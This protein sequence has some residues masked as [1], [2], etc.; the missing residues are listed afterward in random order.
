LTVEWWSIAPFVLLLA[1]IAVLPL[2]RATERAWER[3]LVKLAVALA[4]GVPIAVW[5]LAAGSGIE[6]AHALVEYF[7][8]IT[9]LFSLFVVSGGI[10][11]SGDIR[12]TPRN[13]TIFLAVG[14]VIAS[15]IGT[16]GA[17]MLL[18]RP[19]LNTNKERAHRVHTVVF[20]IFIVANCGGLLTPLGDPP[21]FLGMLR[22]VPFTWTFS[23]WPQWLFVGAMLL[24]TY[25][26]LDRRSYARESADAIQ[27][28]NTE[29]V[30]LGVRGGI[31]LAFLVV[32]IIAVAVVPSVDLHAI[33]AGHATFAQWMPWREIA[34]GAAAGASYFLGDKIARFE[35]NQFTWTPIR[36]VAAL[37]IGIFL[38]MIPA[39]NFLGQVAPDLPLN[40]V[41][42]F[43]F[44][45]GLS[46]VLDNAPTYATFFEM[47]AQLPGDPRV[48]GVPEVLLTAI[49]LGAVMGG[50]MTYIG[51]GPNFMT[52][53]VADS[54]GVKM[55]SFG[56]Y[57]R[58]SVVYLAP[59]LT[60]MVLIFIADGALWTI[61]GLVLTAVLI[62]R[63]VW[64]A[65]PKKQR[66]RVTAP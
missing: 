13:N 63:A 48:A 43:I 3:N 1:C 57:V 64:S 10:F 14:G 29:R 61:I 44:S 42:L 15:F 22:G 25:Y 35:L 58:W 39:L 30:R 7:Q 47:A 31:N 9:L 53:S 21:L 55:P 45:G 11:L 24:L 18:I 51:N 38:T 46:S 49:S 36:E 6:V 17:A 33:E 56:G 52:K 2:V 60:A 41:T 26:A 28:D 54:A 12:A 4:L 27:L 62:G 23:L 32:I 66:D 19:I 59:V 20:A 50:A 65:R 37:F 8:F 5:F 34:M 16:T 40:E